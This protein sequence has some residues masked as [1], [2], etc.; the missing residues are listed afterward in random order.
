MTAKSPGEWNPCPPGELA[1]LAA[2]LTY[3]RRLRFA[4]GSAL[5]L[6]AAAGIVGGG[7]YAYAALAARSSEA[8]P[9]HG[10]T[11]SDS[12]ADK[13]DCAGEDSRPPASPGAV[14]APKDRG[15]PGR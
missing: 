9:C 1:S 7:W 14:S 3:R 13:G 2:R 5:V 8:P 4:A 15:A 10:E 11:T 6:I 12:N